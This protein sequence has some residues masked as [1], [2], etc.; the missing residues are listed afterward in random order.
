MF[1]YSNMQEKE[2]ANEKHGFRS[3]KHQGFVGTGYFDKVQ[4][5]I[6]QGKSSTTAMSGSTEEEQFKVKV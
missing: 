1:A 6:M 5:A 3:A 4:N 2:F